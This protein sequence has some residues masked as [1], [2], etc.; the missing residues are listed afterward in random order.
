MRP[1]LIAGLSLLALFISLF[2]AHLFLGLST[3]DFNIILRSLFSTLFW[4]SVICA[5]VS[6]IVLLYSLSLFGG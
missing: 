1:T 4:L 5:A 6:F 2:C 3:E